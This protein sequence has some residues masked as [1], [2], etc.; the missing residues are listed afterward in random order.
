M[1]NMI[2]LL[3]YLS[4]AEKQTKA[5]AAGLPGLGAQKAPAPEIK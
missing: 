4:Y 3:F 1:G 2:L 5:P